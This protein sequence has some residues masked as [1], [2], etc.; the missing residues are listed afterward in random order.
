MPIAV[1]RKANGQRASTIFL[2]EIQKPTACLVSITGISHSPCTLAIYF[3]FVPL[4][5]SPPDLGEGHLKA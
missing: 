2:Q 3:S 1:M 4:S 5:A